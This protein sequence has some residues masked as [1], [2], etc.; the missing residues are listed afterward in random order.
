MRQS[1]RS[2]RILPLLGALLATLTALSCN[3]EAGR[4][5]QFEIELKSAPPG[6]DATQNEIARVLE[7]RASEA[8]LKNFSLKWTGTTTGLVR[9][10][11][12]QDLERTARRFALRGTMVFRV[13][14]MDNQFRAALPAIDE[15]LAKAGIP[16]V[17]RTAPSAIPGQLLDTE[18]ATTP[19]EPGPLGSRLLTYDGLPGQF[20]SAAA[21]VALVD[22][23]I[24]LPEVEALMP[25][26]VDLVWG[27]EQVTEDGKSYRPLYAVEGRPMVWGEQLEDAVARFDDTTQHTV[28]QFTLTGAGGERF[29]QETGQ[30]V[31]D[32]LAIVL[33]GEVFGRPPVIRDPIGRY[34]QIDLGEESLEQV[35]DLA[36]ALKAGALPVPVRVVK[37]GFNVQ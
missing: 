8:G 30:H 17:E 37:A 35:Q 2:T 31:G 22:S 29:E 25:Q 27:A 23:L 9:V 18:P 6:G 20:L 16:S 1:S 7:R 24:R 11:G 5:A 36:L 21:D 26:S 32:H 34:G 14:D 33:D 15:V 12:V 4:T 13:T 3:A 10:T 19:T 28:V